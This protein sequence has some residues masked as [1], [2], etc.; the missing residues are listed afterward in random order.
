M[1]RNGSIAAT[2]AVHKVKVA[3]EYKNKTVKQNETNYLLENAKRGIDSFEALYKDIE[4]CYKNQ[5]VKFDGSHIFYYPELNIIMA[6]QEAAR[7][8]IHACSND[9]ILKEYLVSKKLSK[10]SKRIELLNENEVTKIFKDYKKTNRVANYT[11][12]LCIDE[13]KELLCWTIYNK[14]AVVCKLED[15]DAGMKSALFSMYNS[16]FNEL[17]IKNNISTVRVP[18]CVRLHKKISRL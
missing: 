9:E 12:I 14:K 3:D 10:Y 16:N 5:V 13:N 4:E 6:N 8:D 15:Y 1:N 17:N 11:Q 18:V 7:M 2:K